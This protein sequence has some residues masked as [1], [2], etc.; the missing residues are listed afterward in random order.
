MRKVVMNL[1]QVREWFIKESG[2]YDL[3]VDAL[4]WAD[5]GADRYLNAAQRMLDRM[6]TTPRTLGRNFQVVTSGKMGVRFTDCRAVKEVWMAADGDGRWK[7]EKKSQTWLR[8]YYSDMQTIESG[9][10]IYYAPAVLR[11]APELEQDILIDVNLLL[12]YLDIASPLA[13]EYNGVIFL[14]PA[15]KEYMIE[16]WGYFYTP[17]LS[18]DTDT[19]YWTLVHPELLVMAGQLMLEK[20]M[21][22]TEGVKDWLGVIK[23]ELQGID[24]D[25]VEEDIADVN[26]ME[27]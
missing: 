16:V 22:N 11:M 5:A 25:M 2:R 23:A 14:P 1:V 24:F 4:A 12:V 27:G 19:S 3:V 6:Q 18:D 17:E 10:P 7:L 26:Q 20:F 8:D 15:D 21:R 9:Q 13:A